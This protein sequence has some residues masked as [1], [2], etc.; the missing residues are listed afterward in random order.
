MSIVGSK[1]GSVK[2]FNDS[3]GYGFI[4]P[5]GSEKDLFVHFSSVVGQEG[6]KTL[7]ED[8]RVAFDV[9]KTDRGFNAINVSIVQ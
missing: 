5:D 2:W 8:D 3:R 4:T 6:Q 9:E 1:Q 7:R